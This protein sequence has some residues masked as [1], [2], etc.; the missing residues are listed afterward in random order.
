MWQKETTSYIT[1]IEQV[2]SPSTF[3]EH[4]LSLKVCFPEH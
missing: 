3:L 2:Y 4:I 1:K